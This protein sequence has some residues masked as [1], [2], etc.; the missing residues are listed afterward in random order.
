M[1]TDVS[2]VDTEQCRSLSA[3]HDLHYFISRQHVKK[4]DASGPVGG[5]G[6]DDVDGPVKDADC[7][8]IDP[9]QHF[10]P[11]PFTEPITS[12]AD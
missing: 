6:G 9:P 5:G 10:T 11:G 3:R 7:W 4:V 8:A 12:P 2:N 1:K